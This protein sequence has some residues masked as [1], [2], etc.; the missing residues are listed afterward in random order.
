[1]PGGGDTRPT[2]DRVRE[3]LF[4]VLTAWAG[5]RGTGAA[6]GAEKA[7]AGLSFCDLYAGSGA[8]GLEAASRGAAPVL[9]V[10]RSRRVAAVAS[11]NARDL[12][13]PVR[14]VAEPVEVL[15][16]RPAVQPYDM[17]FADPPYEL[18]NRAV[19]DVLAGLLSSGW[20]AA[21]GLVVV[22]RSARSDAITWPADVSPSRTRTY[23]ETVLHIAER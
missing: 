17:I 18:A 21:S 13:L 1:M 19:E 14:V 7:L 15:V 5:R 20:L 23:G 3:A 12:E 11:G 9:L 8:V 10:E 16:R 2:T 4:S 22:E 6:A